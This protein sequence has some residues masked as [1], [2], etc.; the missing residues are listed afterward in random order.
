MEKADLNRECNCR[1]I[2]QLVL[3]GQAT[4]EETERLRAHLRECP[5]CMSHYEIDSE[6]VSML[7]SRCCGG[8]APEDLVQRVKITLNIKD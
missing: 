6:V 7:K 2:L 1:E 5:Q 3:D 4:A 8:P